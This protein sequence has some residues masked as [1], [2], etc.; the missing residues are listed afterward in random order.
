MSMER[1]FVTLKT[2]AVDPR[3]RV[4]FLR[5][6]GKAFWDLPGGRLEEGEEPSLAFA[7]EFQEETGCEMLKGSETEILWM[8]RWA[9]ASGSPIIAFVQRAYVPEGDPTLSEEHDAFLWHD[10]RNAPPEGLSVSANGALQALREREGM[11]A[12]ILS[13]PRTDGLI[14]VYTGDGKGKTTAALGLT[15]RAVGAGKRVGIVYFDKGGEGHY[16]ERKVLRERF[17]DVVEY[18][19]TGR[20]RIDPETGRFDFSRTETDLAEARR[21]IEAARAMFKKGYDVVVLD[22]LCSTVSL[23]ML[24]EEEAL[25]LLEEKP[26][27][28]E[29]ILTG[30]NAPAS[31][32]ACAALVTNMQLKTHYFYAG[33]SAREGIDF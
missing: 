13:E 33:V 21:G 22:E 11:V 6:A 23:Q 28:T 7:R 10:P 12:P 24:P 27:Q 4:L 2:L 16:S 18:V 20:D 9:L 14:Q 17:S 8:G 19:A 26:P 31:F 30:R 25:R 29:L 5:R 1:P 3:G 32:L 15:I